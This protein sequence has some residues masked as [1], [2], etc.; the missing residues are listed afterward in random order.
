MVP[1]PFIWEFGI[2]IPPFLFRPG[3]RKTILKV[4]NNFKNSEKRLVLIYR[5]LLLCLYSGIK[6]NKI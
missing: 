6:L 4:W 3:F 2:F 1:I 5:T